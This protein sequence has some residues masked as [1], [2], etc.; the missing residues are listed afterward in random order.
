MTYVLVDID[1]PNQQHTNK[2]FTV[3]HTPF[4]VSAL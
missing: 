3:Q 4:C 2:I 1:W